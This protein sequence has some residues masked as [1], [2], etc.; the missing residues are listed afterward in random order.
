MPDVVVV[1]HTHWDREWYRTFQ[2][3]RLRLVEAVQRILDMLEKGRLPYFL[4]D[5]QT[6]MLDDYLE[7]RPQDEDRLQALTRSGKLG[8]GPWYILPDEL[9][10]SGESLVRNL[11]FGRERM[12][13][14][15]AGDPV[16]Y[17]PDMFGHTAQMPQILRNFGMDRAIVWRGVEPPAEHFWWENLA[18]DGIAT[19]YLP[20]GYCN[21]HFWAPL[22]REERAARHAEFVA[23]HRLPGPHLLLAG[24]DHLAPNAD[25]PEVAAEQGARLGRVTDALVAPGRGDM[26]VVRGELR[27]S[28]RPL[29][30]LLPDV[31]SARM[32]IKQEN[33]EVQDLWE[34]QVEPLLALQRLAGQGIEMGFW[35]E[36][37]ELILK[38]Q[39]H[40]SICGCSIDEVHRE[41]SARFSQ[42]RSL[43]RDLVDRAMDAFAPREEAPGVLVFNP[44]GWARA[45]WVEVV[46]E[47]PRLV[48][49]A[50][51]DPPHHAASSAA[52][53]DPAGDD[54]LAF[55]TRGPQAA[56]EPDRKVPVAADPALAWPSAH[57]EG[58][59]CVFLGAA[60]GEEFLA[61]ILYHPDW[62]PV[63]RYRLLAW[64]ELPPFGLRHLRLA[65]GEGAVGSAPA[66][67]TAAEN[68]VE[69][70]H[71]RVEVSDG[72]LKLLIK[73]TGETV[74]DL[75]RFVDG[76]DAGDEYTYSPPAEDRLKMSSY[77]DYTVVE[78]SAARAVLEVE[79]GLGI[80]AALL[81]DRQRRSTLVV[82]TAIK[83]RIT[84]TAGSRTLQFESR[85]ENWAQDHRLRAL[86]ATGIAHPGEIV[87]EVAF[88]FVDRKPGRGLGPLPVP[89]THEAVPPTFP[90]LGV[91]ALEGDRHSAQLLAP[92]LPEAEIVM[93]GQAVAI[94]LLRCVGWLSRDD[95]RT[96]GGGAG[97]HMETPDAQCQGEH[98]FRYALRIG[99]P[100]LETHAA[101]WDALPDLD[102]VRHAP[103]VRPTGGHRTALAGG[104]VAPGP[105]FAPVPAAVVVSSLKPASTGP[106]I[107]M[108]A[109]NPTPEPRSFPLRAPAGWRCAP[110]DMAESPHASPGKA[111][112]EV[113][114]APGEIVTLSL[115]S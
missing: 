92:G 75:L 107:V 85:L 54:L 28:G 108:R 6:V 2:G 16:G 1:P 67:V 3:Y 74:P 21:V 58:A 78:A 57:L 94:T 81:P 93:G 115:N 7:I 55:L 109:C 102:H 9:L 96:R 52:A 77:R 97:P 106:G 91:V 111:V 22:A 73:D 40:D 86:V 110:C 68:S 36:G 32:G 60:D 83:T 4:L 76:G 31:A 46:A 101:W 48:L 103:V 84:L 34:R 63:R 64:L 33:A 72:T 41:M 8:I 30:Y 79:H 45:G 59:P 44:S 25:L 17:L 27:Q 23:A 11:Q 24:C 71:L 43:G 35:R 19:V 37:W 29:Q 80:P 113:V 39:P 18:G 38:N 66:D 87:S 20:T 62:K 98:V 26:P 61:D 53:P 12:D 49:P 5:G 100:G 70:A 69:N 90:H 56:D 99:P 82:N 105:W 51:A 88:G 42:A 10:V 89:P 13:R 95:L 15:G 14:F 114:V 112:C 50:A 47:V 104:A 65:A